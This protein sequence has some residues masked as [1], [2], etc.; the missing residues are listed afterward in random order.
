MALDFTL[1]SIFLVCRISPP[2]VCLK[3][4]T[5]SAECGFWVFH[6][7]LKNSTKCEPG[8]HWC[9]VAQDDFWQWILFER[10]LLI[11]FS[12]HSQT[13]CYSPHIAVSALSS[14]L[15][16]LLLGFQV[17]NIPPKRS[18]GVFIWTEIIPAIWFIGCSANSCVSTIEGG[19]K[20]QFRSG[21]EQ[22]HNRGFATKG[23]LLCKSI[24]KVKLL[25]VNKL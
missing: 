20:F 4:Y 18:G 5:E 3:Q 23:H 24:S 25:Q 16:Q 2:S 17:K 8:G 9:L 15:I 13:A 10:F 7:H 14:L 19:N 12:A 6:P 11:S 22:G 1:C 21:N